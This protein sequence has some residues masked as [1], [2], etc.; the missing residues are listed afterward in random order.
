MNRCTL[1]WSR[2]TLLQLSVL[3]KN[4]FN[5]V[6]LTF[7]NFK[8]PF[9]TCFQTYSVVLQNLNELLIDFSPVFTVK[10]KKFELPVKACALLY[11]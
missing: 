6:Y 5:C 3:A 7:N 8:I 1:G 4:F 10:Q 11:L 2:L 9:H